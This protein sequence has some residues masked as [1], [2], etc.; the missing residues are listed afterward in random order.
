MVFFIP[1]ENYSFALQFSLS[2]RSRSA[3]RVPDAKTILYGL[4]YFSPQ[5]HRAIAV[6]L[7]CF[8]SALFVY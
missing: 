6:Q 5:H 4:I 1:T 8:S 3:S 7:V 2:L